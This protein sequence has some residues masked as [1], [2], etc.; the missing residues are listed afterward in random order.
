MGGQGDFGTGKLGD[1]GIGEKQGN[2]KTGRRGIREPGRQGD[3]GN[4]GNRGTRE[5]GYW[6]IWR[7]G[8]GVTGGLCNGLTG[9]QEKRGNQRTEE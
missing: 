3:K 2:G 9:R 8:D 4:K 6:G 1:R 5:L 7:L